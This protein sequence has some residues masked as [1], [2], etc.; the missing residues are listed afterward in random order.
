M[1]HHLCYSHTTGNP[2]RLPYLEQP[3]RADQQRIEDPRISQV[4]ENMKQ[5]LLW[6]SCIKVVKFNCSCEKIN[7]SEN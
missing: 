3:S 1:N 7:Q 6:A 2:F 4:P 5:E